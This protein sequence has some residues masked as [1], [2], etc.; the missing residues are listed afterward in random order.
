MATVN[1]ELNPRPF[2]PVLLSTL[3]CPK[4]YSARGTQLY[5]RKEEKLMLILLI[6]LRISELKR[7]NT[8][9]QEKKMYPGNSFIAKI[10][11]SAGMSSNLMAEARHSQTD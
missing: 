8:Q 9:Y 2:V 4:T 5:F 7:G 3:D 11:A 10:L 1:P 6:L